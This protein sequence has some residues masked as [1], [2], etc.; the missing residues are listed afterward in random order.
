[1]E[2]KYPSDP[3]NDALGVL[4]QALEKRLPEDRQNLEVVVNYFGC[5]NQY[6]CSLYYDYIL[7]EQNTHQVESEFTFV[8]RELEACNLETTIKNLN[9]LLHNHLTSYNKVVDTFKEFF[10]NAEQVLIIQPEAGNSLCIKYDRNKQAINEE[11]SQGQLRILFLLS[12]ILNPDFPD[13]RIKNPLPF[14]HYS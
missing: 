1:M 7:N 5:T 9:N 3:K 11:I 2:I 6:V 12:I 8:P 4:R 14:I 10:P 13:I